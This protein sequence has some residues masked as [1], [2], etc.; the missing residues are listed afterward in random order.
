MSIE[1]RYLNDNDTFDFHCEMCGNCCRNRED[2]QLSGYDIMR[3]CGYLKISVRELIDRYCEVLEGRS[4]LLPSILLRPQGKVK[5][6]PFLEDNKCKVQVCKPTV[7]ALYPLGRILDSATYNV[8]YFLQKIDCSSG[9]EVQTLKEWLHKSMTDE[10]ENCFVYW[11]QIKVFLTRFANTVKFE[12]AGLRFN[13]L[14]ILM[15]ENY[16]FSGNYANQ[17]KERLEL[18]ERF[19]QDMLQMASIQDS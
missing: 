7:C 3:I 15:Y 4:S 5:I 1:I 12:N 2:I 16:D 19:V 6:C 17:L 14:F 8:R 13:T 11:S 18:T 9:K 10:A